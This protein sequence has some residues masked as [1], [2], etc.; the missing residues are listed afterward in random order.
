[1]PKH[2][3]KVAG[4]L[5]ENG[6]TNYLPML[7]TVK[8]RYEKMKC[9]RVPMFPSYVFIYL[10]HA[11]EYFDGLNMKGVLYYVRFG[12]LVARIADSIVED[13]KLVSE[14]GKN[15]E[16]SPAEFQQGQI[17]TIGEGPLAGLNCE[18]I[19]YK[20]EE[21]I[22]VRLTLLRRN[23]VMEM[24]ALRLIGQPSTISA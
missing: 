16:V 20:N 7:T 22:L 21:K 1:M 13:L 9:L 3:K 2:E 12:G 5:T 15:V 6:L 18:V 24:P 4:Q 14:F 23:V 8:S 19:R 11:K 10:N 17:L